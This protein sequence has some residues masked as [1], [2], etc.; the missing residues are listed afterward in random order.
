MGKFGW[1]LPPG[2][3]FSDLP[4]NEPVGP[5]ECCG[6]DAE[7]WG[8]PGGCICPEC[9]QCGAVGDPECYAH[10]NLRY[11]VRQVVSRDNRIELD[12]LAIIA[13]QRYWEQYKEE[14]EQYPDWV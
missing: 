2:C 4:G 9:P 3:S 14:R 6:R 13:E 12:R 8:E 7:V 1:S 11:S 5:C 10:H